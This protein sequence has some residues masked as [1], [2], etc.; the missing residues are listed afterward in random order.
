M[1][2]I[3]Y[4]IIPPFVV[5]VLVPF[6]T[7]LITKA[8]APEWLKGVLNFLLSSLAAGIVNLAI[9]DYHTFG[10]FLTALI[11]AWLASMRMHYTGATKPIVN[12]TADIGIGGGT[13]N[14]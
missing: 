1:D 7:A 13:N 2:A 14:G 8:T 12:A 5:G 9:G 3:D 4:T 11:V 6:L 10:S